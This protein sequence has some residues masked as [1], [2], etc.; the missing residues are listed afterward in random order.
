MPN[1]YFFIVGCPRSG[2]TLLQRVVSAHPQITV[3]PEAPWI[4]ELHQ[5]ST[6]ITLGGTVKDDPVPSLLGHPKFAR[7][8]ISCDQ[9]S[10]L[11][12]QNQ[13]AAYSTL[14]QAIFD[15]YGKLQNKNLVGNKTPGLVRRLDTVHN[16]WPEARIIHIVRDGR[17][18]YL[19]MRN[20]PLRRWKLGTRLGVEDPVSTMGLW[21]E[22]NVQMGRK[23][24]EALGPRL[25]REVLYEKFVSH[26]EEACS[27]LCTFLEVPFSEAM[28]RFY[29]S[30]NTRKTSRPITPGLRDW[31]TEMSAED[32]EQFE[33]AAGKMLDDLGYPRA[34]PHPSCEL[35]DRSARTRGLVLGQS[36][37]YARA[38]AG[39]EMQ[40]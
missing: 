29:E 18:V 39:R 9:L 8:G 14:V 36:P 4:Y 16:L 34:C 30:G 31:R 1:P 40:S 32:V 12:N 24:G 10:A 23:A 25:Y 22:L 5:Q 6:A 20:R 37:R 35:V 2:T 26:P 27:E 3:M 38:F 11:I 28:M 19:S 15:L 7:L 21:W 33:S 17:N 13:R